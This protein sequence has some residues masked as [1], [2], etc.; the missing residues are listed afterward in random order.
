MFNS[1]VKSVLCEIN[2]KDAY[3]KFY[4]SIPENEFMGIVNFYG[5]FDNLM[6]LVMNSVKS[7]ESNLEDVKKFVNTYK[8]VPNEVRV[9][10]VRRFKSG[11]YETLEDADLDLNMLV[12]CGVS[13]EKALSDNGLL[14]IYEDEKCKITCT[15]TYAA[16]HHYYGHTQWC[17]AS[18][19]K[20]QYDGWL[21]FLRYT[22][23]E[24]MAIPYHGKNIDFNNLKA[25]LVQCVEKESKKTYQFQIC[26]NHEIGLVCDETDRSIRPENIE[27]TYIIEN[28][29]VENLSTWMELTKKNLKKEYEYIS[30][31]DVFIQQKK[32]ILKKRYFKKL[33]VLNKKVKEFNHKKSLF[34]ANKFA[35]ISK[36]NLIKDQN[37]IDEIFNL[38][39]DLYDLESENETSEEV[40]K[41]TDKRLQSVGY[42]M[43]YR[44]WGSENL[45]FLIFKPTM[46]IG[47]TVYDDGSYDPIIENAVFTVN[48]YF[49]VEIGGFL[50][51]VFIK[52]SQ[53][54]EKLLFSI[55]GSEYYNIEHLRSN[56]GDTESIDNFYVLR[57]KDIEK[58]ED[59]WLLINLNNGLNVKLP[60]DFDCERLDSY[61]FCI[62]NILAYGQYPYYSQD[63]I[64]CTHFFDVNSLN[65]I[66]DYFPVKMSSDND[67]F[68]S[69]K[70]NN[71]YILYK[72]QLIPFKH[73]L[74]CEPNEIDAMISYTEDYFLITSPKRADIYEFSNLKTPLYDNITFV[75]YQDSDNDDYEI[76]L[77]FVTKNGENKIMQ[78]KD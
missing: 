32:E 5:K 20:G 45:T 78:L 77:N 36:T 47:K 18:D 76:N 19:R 44:H 61:S 6:K 73:N 24:D 39:S 33:D 21:M 10:F 46:G 13:S 7:G 51:C 69:G 35:D 41:E 3:D 42:L 31:K 26:K 64:P 16:N 60:K 4:N 70:D 11:E 1:I 58:K 48:N 15:T 59:I 2:A 9:E 49:G 71:C 22:F 65:P 38:E 55:I 56:I 28:L 25:C 14:N 63:N 62:D 68:F 37:F 67:I 50:F 29:M 30:N 72:N 17:T 8:S 52:I 34:V 40:L 53:E 27:S 54:Q 57:Y 12:S 75:S 74:N 43:P 66:G 23:K